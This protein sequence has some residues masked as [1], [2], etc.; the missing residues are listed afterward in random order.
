MLYNQSFLSSVPRL[1]ADHLKSNL[2]KSNLQVRNAEF[3]LKI[4]VSAGCGCAF[5]VGGSVDEAADSSLPEIPHWEFFV[6][7][8]WG[9][10]IELVGVW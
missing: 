2:L 1:L 8:R 6:G 4:M 9:E 5:H 10:L 7:D 3:S